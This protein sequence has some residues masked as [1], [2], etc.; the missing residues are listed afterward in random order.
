MWWTQHPR[1]PRPASTVE[2][3]R[4]A[5]QKL[6]LVIFHSK[7]ALTSLVVNDTW[8][9]FGQPPTG[10]PRR[11]T[12]SS[13]EQVLVLALSSHATLPVR[14]QVLP[15]LPV[16]RT[17]LTL[18]Q[19]NALDTRLGSPTAKVYVCDL[20]DSGQ[21]RDAVGDA[22]RDFG[23]FDVV[24]LN[25]GRGQGCYFEEIRDSDQI[26][27]ML[28]LNVN[29]VINT[30]HHVLPSVPKS[31]SSRLVFISS[32]S[33]L[34]G[35]PYRTVYCAS[36]HALT[37]FANTLRI[38]LI[39]TYGPEAPKITL[40]NF[41]EVS[42]TQLNAGRMDFGAERRPAEFE[43]KGTLS[44]EE[45]CSGDMVAVA[46]GARELGHPPKISVLLPFY[47]LIPEIMDSIVLRHVKKTHSRPDGGMEK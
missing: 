13:R 18:L 40:I 45:A 30:L 15:C 4:N 27:Y 29:G 11:S 24:V 34:L 6:Q 47:R 28:K 31:S 23:R 41:S 20:T 37:G 46:A 19:R 38:E 2:S 7:I 8:D 44:V 26:D 32:V 21:I 12:S 42:G 9:H 14:E 16:A 3:T 5:V 36:K 22:V 39:D 25:A 10:Q 1:V 43:T 17:A 33:G 35:V